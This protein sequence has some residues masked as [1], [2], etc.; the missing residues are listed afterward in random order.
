VTGDAT[1]PEPFLSPLSLPTF[2]SPLLPPQSEEPGGGGILETTFA[3]PL[4]PP[5]PGGA[6]GGE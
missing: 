5:E 4:E 3:S 6:V 1:T 2:D